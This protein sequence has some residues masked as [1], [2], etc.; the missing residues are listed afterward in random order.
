MT[1]I[2]SRPLA[3]MV[4]GH[5]AFF[6]VD[7]LSAQRGAE[8]AAFYSDPA[9]VLGMIR[10]SVERGVTGM[11]M[12]TH[13]RAGP[14]A[15]MIRSDKVLAETL[16]IYPLLPYAQ[17][18]VTRANEVGLVNVVMENLK[19][20]SFGDK[21]SF[22]WQGTKGVLTKD[23]SGILSALIRMELNAFRGL[24]LGAVFLHDA[25]TDLALG[26]GL[27]GVFAFYVEELA[28]SHDTQPAFA[29]K[30][31]PLLLQR[32]QE[33]GLPDPVVLTHFN[34]VGYHM[35]PGIDQCVEAARTKRAR[36]MAMGTLAS[37][38]LKPDEAYS[39][40]ADIGGIE[41]VVVGVSSPKHADET[42]SA[43]KANGW[44]G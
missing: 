9:R 26:L 29:T 13:E 39:W 24:R 19:G 15:E 2:D 43:L 41:S 32:F 34:K 10:E 28:K 31:L 6:G 16:Q 22:L 23:V 14:I 1:I 12:S 25:L 17:K 4:L 18:Y 37:G 20:S 44:G 11:M 5:N 3:P 30:N 8:R 35:N 40:L 27:E 21:L 33:W 42:F 38:F 36:I 7:H